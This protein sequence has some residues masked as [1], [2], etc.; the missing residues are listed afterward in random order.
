M[1]ISVPFSYQVKAIPYKHKLESNLR[2]VENTWVDVP[3]VDGS[4]LALALVVQ[5][6]EGQDVERIYTYA[7]E[8]WVK[9]TR[10]DDDLP[11][12]SQHLPAAGQRIPEARDSSHLSRDRSIS[13][14]AAAA[15]LLGQVG[16]LRTRTAGVGAYE[17]RNWMV[18]GQYGPEFIEVTAET[19]KARNVSSS[20][21]EERLQRA[22]ILAQK[23]SIAVDGVLYHRVAEPCIVAGAGLLSRDVGWVFEIGRAHV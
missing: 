23:H 7:G 6:V 5:D 14:L 20:T 13:E 9:D 15:K 3:D 18:N 21:R 12:D 4:N 2:M 11:F 19:E 22:M 8:F 17:A 10:G 1:R 16:M